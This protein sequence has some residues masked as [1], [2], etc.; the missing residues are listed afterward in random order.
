MVLHSC[1][2]GDNPAC[3]NPAH[4]RLGTH[5]DNTRDA[6]ERG[7]HLTGDAHPSRT[8][9]ERLKRGE[10]NGAAKLTTEAV[11]EIRRQ[12][13]AGGTTYAKLGA[14]FGVST[15]AIQWVVRRITWRHVT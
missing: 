14:Q 15:L 5:T 2:E 8:Q 10:A 6:V 11:R 4:L 3:V 1:P 7:Q 13:A 12:H 9:P